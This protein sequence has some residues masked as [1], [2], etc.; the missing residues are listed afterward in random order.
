M[1][2]IR[3]ATVLDE[4][5]ELC[6]KEE[7]QL[8]NLSIDGWERELVEFNPHFV[9]IES[10]W[11]GKDKGWNKKVSL[12][13]PELET[14]IKWCRNR[15]IPI[16]FWNKEDPI[17]YER[18]KWVA[19][20][21]DFVFT[22]NLDSIERY[23][24]EL[25]HNKVYLLPFAASP[26]Y[27]NPIEN[28]VRSNRMLFAGAY[29]PNFEDR[30]KDTDLLFRVA[31][32]TT[33]LMYDRN[34]KVKETAHVFPEE[35]S[36]FIVGT[37]ESREIDKAYKSHRYGITINTIKNSQTMF[38]RRAF[39]Q[40]ACNTLNVSTYSKAMDNF[41]GKLILM[42]N[43]FD[44]LKNL[45]LYIENNQDKYRKIRLSGLR[46]VFQ[47]HTYRDRLSYIISVVL[48]R[49]YSDGL[50][51][52]TVISKI[53]D[54][55]SLERLYAQFNNQSYKYKNIIIIYNQSIPKKSLSTKMTGISF[56]S[57]AEVKN[58]KLSSLSPDGYFAFFHNDDYYGRNYL[59]DLGIATRY[60]K[61]EAIGKRSFL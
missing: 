53:D 16:I 24:Q 31:L 30:K 60:V 3:I 23:K 20:S 15:E 10:A 4:F 49:R 18:F 43:D 14:M 19:K 1:E 52:I 27:H 13:S 35:F 26:K 32:D 55:L 44:R 51:W 36:S 11:D 12:H 46:K 9:F 54:I 5:S 6:F 41:F 38:A 58:V 7:C 33:G 39:E 37:L 50:P 34:L 42:S 59:M 57:E 25:G 45:I 21:V 8:L 17:H 56:I 29:Y 40:M 2:N 22:T 61:S 28:D 48:D 47:Q